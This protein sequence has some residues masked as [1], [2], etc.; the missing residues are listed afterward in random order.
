MGATDEEWRAQEVKER[1]Q[2][3]ESH[4]RPFHRSLEARWELLVEF[5]R[6]PSEAS[7]CDWND[8]TVAFTVFSL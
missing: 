7:E 6:D 8:P 3:E 2:G 5:T 1:A 4:V